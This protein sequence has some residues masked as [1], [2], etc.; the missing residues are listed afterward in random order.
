MVYFSADLFYSM[1]TCPIYLI[2]HFLK[3]WIRFQNVCSLFNPNSVGAY[4]MLLQLVLISVAASTKGECIECNSPTLL[5]HELK[6]TPTF[7]DDNKCCPLEYDCSNIYNRPEGTCHLMGKYYKPGEKPAEEDVASDCRF[8]F[9]TC[10][11]NGL[12]NCK[13]PSDSCAEY[14]LPVL[15]EPGCYLTYKHNLCCSV[16]QKCPPFSETDGKCEVGET[17]YKEG[18]RFSHPTKKCASCICDKSFNGSFDHLCQLRN[19]SSELKHS[20]EI[21]NYCAPYYFHSD[22][23]CPHSWIC[24]S[25]GGI[26]LPPPTSPLLDTQCRFGTYAMSIGEKYRFENTTCEC[27]IPPF[28]TC[29]TVE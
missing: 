18:Q 13:L 26:F 14:W 23:C 2:T 5:Y 1:I 20:K 15:K 7:S 8:P 24:P 21:H 29:K 28:L 12:F 22:D 6:C 19:C 4:D 11:E 10:E 27:L 25:E 17:T 3:L 9:C 16:D